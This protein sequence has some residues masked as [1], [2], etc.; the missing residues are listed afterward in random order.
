MND[1]GAAPPQRPART[2]RGGHRVLVA[3]A[4]VR[5]AVS[6]HV[7]A[8]GG[9]LR[10][11]GIAMPRLRRWR[12]PRRQDLVLLPTPY[13]GEQYAPWVRA[14]VERSVTAYFG[15]GLPGICDWPEGE[16]GLAS[17]RK[18]GFIGASSPDEAAAFVADGLPED[19]VVWTGNP[20]LHD[21]LQVPPPAP[22][23]PPVL[24]WA[25][26]WSRRWVHGEPG[27][28]N[29]PQSVLDLQ[30]VLRWEPS[31]RV[32]VRPHP[33]L[34]FAG[35]GRPPAYASEHWP[36]G[37]FGSSFAGLHEVLS[38]P[39]VTLSRRSLIEDLADSTHV[40]TDGISLIGYALAAG[41]TVRVVRRPDSP[42]LGPSGTRLLGV[43]R[44]IATGEET[45]TWL[46]EVLA[47]RDDGSADASMRRRR[48]AVRAEYPLTDRSPGAVFAAWIAAR[49]ADRSH[50]ERVPW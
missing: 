34:P 50:E 29:W 40:L 21:V 38:H 18:I 11:I 28:S 35:R 31:A 22:E 13:L 27:F 15:Y 46:H 42:V 6:D 4:S 14:V 5:R 20:L 44:A 23:R 2:S 24:L 1:R 3:G 12:T 39:G 10:D 37:E 36:A 49:P 33:L 17:F 30:E 32:V 7:D 8:L 41:R 43:A 19:R 25:P 47:G 45:R 26:H 48:D 9:Q 16:V